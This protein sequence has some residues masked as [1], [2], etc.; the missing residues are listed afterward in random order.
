MEAENSQP[1]FGNFN[2]ILEKSWKKDVYSIVLNVLG[3]NNM[4]SEYKSTTNQSY[5]E[6]ISYLLSTGNEMPKMYKIK[7]LI[8]T[9]ASFT[10]M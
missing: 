8:G 4:W 7:S 2:T 10:L 6:P 3:N 9:P 1:N 5:N